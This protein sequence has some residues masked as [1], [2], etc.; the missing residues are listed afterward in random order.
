MITQEGLLEQLGESKTAKII[1][2]INR[3]V[4]I[5]N[6]ILHGLAEEALS[7]EWGENNYVLK[8]YLAV[9]IIWSIE[10][11]RYTI[12]QDQLYLTAGHLQNRYGTPLYLVIGRNIYDTAPWHLVKAGASINAPELPVPPEIPKPPKMSLGSEI[13]MSHDHILGENAQRVPPLVNTPPVA[14]MCAISGAIQ[15]SIN[16]GLQIPY[17]YHERMQYIIPL[18]LQSREDITLAPD[19]VA[20]VQVNSKS[21]LVRTVL[22]PAMPYD[23]ARIAVRRHD[24]LPHWLLDAWS[25]SVQ[26]GSSQQNDEED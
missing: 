14:Q 2:R 18:Y 12:G 4:T 17:W 13:V 3:F 24:Q 23:K 16:R 25:I 5:P 8:K 11:G 26:R 21:L 7:E 19:V 9:H 10:Q 20:P 15:W 6:N 22:E 1:E